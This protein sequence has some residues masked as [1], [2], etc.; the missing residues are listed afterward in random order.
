[1]TYNT[2]ANAVVTHEPAM[3]AH[4][5]HG[6]SVGAPPPESVTSGGSHD[7]SRPASAPN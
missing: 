6:T 2:V 7:V 1:M 3:S 4:S 5:A